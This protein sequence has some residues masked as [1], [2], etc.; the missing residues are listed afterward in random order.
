MKN[1]ILLTLSLIF[2]SL[3]NAANTEPAITQPAKPNMLDQ[4]ISYAKAGGMQNARQ[5]AEEYLNQYVRPYLT[6]PEITDKP[7]IATQQSVS[8][9][10]LRDRVMG[11]AKQYAPGAQET[12]A[13]YLNSPASTP[14]E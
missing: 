8:S 6:K 10:S 2:V 14:A 1:L 5:K 7:V 11:Y 12:I 9:P 3:A 13:K 4:I